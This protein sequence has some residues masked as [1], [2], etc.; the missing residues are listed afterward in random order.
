MVAISHRS[1]WLAAAAVA[2]ALGIAGCS[3]TGQTQG[4]GSAPQTKEQLE[5]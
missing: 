4:K 1:T 5:S 2:A 3:S